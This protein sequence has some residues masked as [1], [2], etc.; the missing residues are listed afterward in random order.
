MKNFEEYIDKISVDYENQATACW[1][2]DLNNGL[3]FDGCIMGFVL[4]RASAE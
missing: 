1:I 2:A 4:G 3:C